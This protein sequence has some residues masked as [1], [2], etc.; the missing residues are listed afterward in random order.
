MAA[1]K[2]QLALNAQVVANENPLV[3]QHRLRRQR[4]KLAKIAHNL[5]CLKIFFAR[6]GSFYPLHKVFC[7]LWMQYINTRW[8]KRHFYIEKK[9][10]QVTA[11]QCNHNNNAKHPKNFMKMENFFQTKWAIVKWNSIEKCQND[12][13]QLHELSVYFKET[14]P[15]LCCT[16]KRISGYD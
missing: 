10:K 6:N 3:L 5:I 8:N 1:Q 7:W 14:K 15:E 9:Q 2:I 11:M 12:Q 4:P 16:L 13:L